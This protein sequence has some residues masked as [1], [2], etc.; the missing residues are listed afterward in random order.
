MMITALPF[1]LL[2]SSLVAPAPPVAVPVIAPRAGA[3]LTVAARAEIVTAAEI[4][5]KPVAADNAKTDRQFGKRG[6]MS[7]VEFY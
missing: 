1:L 5:F 3:Q 2:A 7:M 4:S 6:D